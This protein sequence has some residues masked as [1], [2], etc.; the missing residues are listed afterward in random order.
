MRVADQQEVIAN[1]VTVDGEQRLG[2]TWLHLAGQ[3]GEKGPRSTRIG[4]RISHEELSEMIGTTRPRVSVFMQRFRNLG[5]IELSEQHFLI[6]KEAK[7]A[8]YLKSIAYPRRAPLPFQTLFVHLSNIERH[9]IRDWSIAE[10]VLRTRSKSLELL[11]TLSVA[12]CIVSL[13]S[14]AFLDWC[15]PSRTASPG[16][17]RSPSLK[18][19]RFCPPDRPPKRKSSLQWR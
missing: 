8:A 9:S 18:A 1:L 7:L 15:R 12:E 17:N 6:V 3:L 11:L 14:W 2:K 10:Q 16:E 5:L 4:L 19:R 13:S